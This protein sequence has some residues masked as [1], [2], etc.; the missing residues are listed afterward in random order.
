MMTLN[1]ASQPGESESKEAPLDVEICTRIFPVM[2]KLSH[3]KDVHALLD[4]VLREGWQM[5][6]ADAGSIELLENNVLNF[7]YIHNDNRFGASFVNR[8]RYASRTLTVDNHS[9]AGWMAS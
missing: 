9:L 7:S 2:E 5:T 4:A 8:Y 3:N 6:R 1:P